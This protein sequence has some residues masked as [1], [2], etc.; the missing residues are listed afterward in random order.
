PA[1]GAVPRAAA[2]GLPYPG[3]SAD[4]PLVLQEPFEDVDRRSER[5]HRRAV[6]DLAVPTAVRQLLTEEPVDE[7]RH[8]DAEIRPA[9]DD[10]A[11]HARLDLALEKPLVGPWRLE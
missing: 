1:L 6:L 7:R 8:V 10:V 11:V 9:G 4:R 5:R 2:A 3:P